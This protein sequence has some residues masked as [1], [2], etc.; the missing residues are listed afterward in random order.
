M[1]L[2]IACVTIGLFLGGTIGA[3][4]VVTILISG[5]VLQQ[6]VDTLKNRVHADMR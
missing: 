4:T 5:I 2:D 3:C 6:V 1:V